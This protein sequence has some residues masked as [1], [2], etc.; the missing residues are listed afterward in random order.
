MLSEQNSP[1]FFQCI[2]DLK[3][4]LGGEPLRRSSFTSV[5]VEDFLELSSLDKLAE[6]GR[7]VG[8]RVQGLLA[9]EADE[10]CVDLALEAADRIPLAAA[11][12]CVGIEHSAVAAHVLVKPSTCPGEGLAEVV[13]G[14][15][16]DLGSHR[17]GNVEA[18]RQDERDSL[19][20]LEAEHRAHIASSLEVLGERVHLG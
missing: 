3:R 19:H 13:G 18:D 2:G 20:S 7:H 15:L 17:I 5:E 9:V 12:G 4:V 8:S 11:A 10:V 16:H 1:G 14:H 6:P